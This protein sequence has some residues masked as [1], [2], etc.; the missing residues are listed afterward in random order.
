MLGTYC[1]RKRRLHC[2][3]SESFPSSTRVPSTHALC[4][5]AGENLNVARQ[6]GPRPWAWPC[7]LC[8]SIHASPSLRQVLPNFVGSVA[9]GALHSAHP[10]PLPSSVFL[11]VFSSSRDDTTPLLTAQAGSPEVSLHF[12]PHFTHNRCITN[13]S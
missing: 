12:C 6:T 3:I 1:R 9:N 10:G 7:N 5:T 13:S 4:S 2:Q 8:F 11:R